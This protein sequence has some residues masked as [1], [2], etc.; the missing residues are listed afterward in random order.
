MAVFRVN[1]NKNYTVMSNYH[2]KDKSLSLK[3]K[4]LLSQML[5]LPDDWDYTVPGLCAINKESKGAIQST[6]KELEERGYLIR[7]KVQNNKGQFDYIYDIYEIPEEENPCMENRCMDVRWMENQPQLNTNI[8]STNKQST[9]EENTKDIDI[10]ARICAEKLKDKILD[11]YPNNVGARKIDCIDRWAKD[12]EKMHRIDGR[13]WQ[14][15]EKAIDW[16][17]NDSFWQQNIWSGANLRKHYDKLE[18]GARAKFL[19]N[20]VI[21]VGV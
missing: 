9:N 15:I 4:G 11:I 18:A 7:T 8:S 19:K 14:N 3:A 12:I 6:L 10:H 1:K 13:S 21:T 5:S 20:G 16:A 2:F 17:M